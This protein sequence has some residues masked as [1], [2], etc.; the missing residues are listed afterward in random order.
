MDIKL[1]KLFETQI[2]HN[3]RTS[4]ENED[5]D[6]EPTSLT[7]QIFKN[8][9]LLFRKLPKGFIVLYEVGSEDAGA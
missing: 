4:G 3:Y 1:K 6:I 7:K 9:K 8:Y 5:F 2:N